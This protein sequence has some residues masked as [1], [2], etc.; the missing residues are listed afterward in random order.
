MTS[1]DLRDHIDWL[2]DLVQPAGVVLAYM[3]EEGI[4][5][6]VFCYWASEEG[7]GGPELGVPQMARLAAL[8]LPIG[9]DVYGTGPADRHR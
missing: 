1:L 7:H 3:R 4:R 2:L 5:Q 8:G 6:D 9:F